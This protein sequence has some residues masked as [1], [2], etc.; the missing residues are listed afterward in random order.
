MGAALSAAP[1]FFYPESFFPF[2]AIVFLFS[3]F[4]IP[5]TSLLISK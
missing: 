3:S 1:F 2:S 4:I 5:L